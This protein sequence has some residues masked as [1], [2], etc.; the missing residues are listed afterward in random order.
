MVSSYF[1][2]LILEKA[3]NVYLYISYIGF[4][5]RDVDGQWIIKLGKIEKEN[6]Q[7]YLRCDKESNYYKSFW[8]LKIVYIL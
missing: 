3:L 7:Y 1:N 6:G 8:S 5:C 4:Q 2:V